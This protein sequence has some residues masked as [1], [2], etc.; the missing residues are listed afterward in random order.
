MNDILFGTIDIPILDKQTAAN[1][2]LAIDD[3][4]SWWDSYRN[5]KMIPLMVK[6]GDYKKLGINNHRKGNEFGWTDYAPTIIIEWFEDVVFSWLQSRA[7]IMALIT[8]PHV[9]NHEHIDCAPNEV[10]T[11]QN[12]FRIVLQGSTDTLYF[13]TDRGAVRAPV[14]D[15]PFLMDGGWPHGMTNNSDEIKVTLALGS[16]W[17]GRDHYDNFNLLLNRNDYTMPVD[18]KKYWKSNDQ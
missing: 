17:R 11:L 14:V 16:P 18:L 3:S 1:S 9:S 13:N 15:G 4:F 12:K 6:M 10:N 5:T 8:Q 7:R 2:I